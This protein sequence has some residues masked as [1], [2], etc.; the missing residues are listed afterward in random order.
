MA[1]SIYQYLEPSELAPF[2]HTISSVT[3]EDT[4]AKFITDAERIIDAYV[5]P[6]PKFYPDMTLDLTATL[7]SGSTTLSTR[8][9]GERRPNYWARGGVYVIVKDGP[10]AL[11]GERR[12][13]VGSDDEQLTLVSGLSADLPSGSGKLI[14]RQ[15]SRFPRACDVDAQ[16][17]PIMPY[18][19]KQAVAWQVEYA[20][21]FGT[22]DFGL[23]DPGVVTQRDAEL[24]S[25]SYGGGYSESRDVS[26]APRGLGRLVAPKA[27][28]VLSRLM[29]RTG[30]LRS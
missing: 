23:G 16:A 30:Y 4:A 6:F 9:V 5:G 13:V 26:V 19:L 21:H 3:D 15:E 10:S 12:L 29:N 27:A 7:S 18:L 8:T 17:D 28:A 20:L 1:K 25:R 24:Q 22:E 2:V 14:L 11:V